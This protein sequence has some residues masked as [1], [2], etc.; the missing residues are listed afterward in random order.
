MRSMTLSLVGLAALTLTAVEARAA[1]KSMDAVL[2]E[3]GKIHDALAK[4]TLAGVP[5]AATR[6]QGLAKSLVAPAGFAELPKKVGAAATA[7]AAAKDLNA[8]R[9]AFKDLS[10]PLASWA[11]SAKP[12]GVAVLNCSMANAD[13][14][15]TSTTVRNPYYGSSMLSCGEVVSKPQAAR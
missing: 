2:A 1:E 4:D 10:A 15:Q 5:E 6:I 11:K 8:A 13:W 7:V 12:A 3:Y 9:A 14:L